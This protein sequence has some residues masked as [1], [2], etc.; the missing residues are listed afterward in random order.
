M[1]AEIRVVGPQAGVAGIQQ[2]PEG[3]V[4]RGPFPE[5]PEEPVSPHFNPRAVGEGVSAI[6]TLLPLP[7]LLVIC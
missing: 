7:R 3:A 2:S 1:E 4:G 6:T 5:H